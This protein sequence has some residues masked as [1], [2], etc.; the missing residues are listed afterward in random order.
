MAGDN[1]LLNTIRTRLSSFDDDALAALANKGLLRRA[2]KDL[3]ETTPELLGEENGRL[4]VRVGDSVVDIPEILNNARCTCPSGGICRHVLTA[5]LFIRNSSP[6]EAESKATISCVDEILSLDDAAI[7]KWAGTP[8]VREAERVLVR[9]M[10]VDIQG[11]RPILFSIPDLNVTCRWIPGGGLEGMVCLCHAPNACRHKVMSVLAYQASLGDRIISLEETIL[12]ASSGA[13]RTREEVRASVVQALHEMVSQGLSRISQESRQRLST[14]SVSAHGVDLPRLER[15]L[16]V[17]ESE[18]SLLLTRDAQADIRNLLTSAARTEALCVA[19]NS[20]TPAL[21]GR[22][23][24]QYD[25][26]GSI[27]LVGV[28][29]R[30]W[31]SRSGYIGLTLYFWDTSAGNWGMWTDARSVSVGGLNPLERYKQEGPWAGCTSP[32]TAIRSVLRLTHAWRNHGGRIS[33]RP[34]TRSTI[35]SP[36]H[37]A[38]MPPAVREWPD[39]LPKASALFAERFYERS[40]QD[41]LVLISPDK[42]GRPG[43]DQ[44]RQEMML[45]V[46]DTHGREL[47]LCLPNTKENESAIG[48]LEKWKY[49]DIQAVFG[50]LRLRMGQL[51]VEPVAIHENEGI[52]NLTLDFDSLKKP[53]NIWQSA[54]SILKTFVTDEEVDRDEDDSPINAL[55]TPVGRLIFAIEAELEMM[56]EGGV[57]SGRDLS[58]LKR[59]L[60]KADSLGLQCCSRPGLDLLNQLE[61]IRQGRAAHF[62]QV[63]ELLLKSYYACRI[64]SS[65]ESILTAAW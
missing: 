16:K 11:D 20:P 44:I 32:H 59:L 58:A 34:A 3:D 56:A 10:G 31:Q 25:E 61:E 1:N 26:V 29:A 7:R 57:V 48:R 63:S 49:A 51:V 22:Y 5:L 43:Y 2:Q 39:L 28:A 65:H 36:A 45:P 30:R 46:Y 54:V 35:L 21:V 37:I 60:A 33:G 62:L 4:Q 13:P 6:R 24:S 41:E 8:M 42:W 12:T 53:V 18:I 55:A 15:Q 27:E 9:G 17:L 19:L 64:A 40:E 38:Q 52:H 50:I 14:L 47:F 23:R